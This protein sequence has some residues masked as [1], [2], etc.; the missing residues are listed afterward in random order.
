[1]LGVDVRF[2][3]MHV[4]GQLLRDAVLRSLNAAEIIGARALLVEPATDRSAAFYEH[5]G[6]RHIAGSTRMFTPLNLPV[7][8][9]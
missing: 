2:Q 5:Y 9:R 7:S 8:A 1:M 4:G 6:F 3:T